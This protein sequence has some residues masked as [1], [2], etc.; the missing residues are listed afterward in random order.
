MYSRNQGQC[1]QHDH[2]WS[3]LAGVQKHAGVC[4]TCIYIGL[5]QESASWKLLKMILIHRK[6]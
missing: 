2:S 4:L 6:V 5:T 1:I 3:M